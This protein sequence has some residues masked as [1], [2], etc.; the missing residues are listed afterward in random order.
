M[1]YPWIHKKKRQSFQYKHVIKGPSIKVIL[2]IFN[3][4]IMPLSLIYV[5]YTRMKDK[6]KQ[7]IIRR[8][9]KEAEPI[10]FSKINNSIAYA[11]KIGKHMYNSIDMHPLFIAQ[12]AKAL[13]ID[14]N[15]VNLLVIENMLNLYC[16]EVQQA[17]SG[18]MALQM[19]EEYKYDLIFMDHIMPDMDGIETTRLIRS[20]ENKNKNT[21]IIVLSANLWDN[22]CN[23]FLSV[24]ANEV[25]QKP[26]EINI[27][28]DVLKKWLP[29]HK[30]EPL[31]QVDKQEE[32]QIVMVDSK[33]QILEQ[34]IDDIADIDLNSGLK[35]SFGNLESFYTILNLA[36][37]EIVPIIQKIEIHHKNGEMIELQK[38]LHSLEN[39]LLNI[40][41]N[42]LTTWTRELEVAMR[43]ENYKIVDGELPGLMSCLIVLS[44]DLEIMLGT[45]QIV[46]EE[47]EQEQRAIQIE[48]S[49]FSKDD[50]IKDLIQL[51][52]CLSISDYSSVITLFKILQKNYFGMEQEIMEE[53]CLHIMNFEYNE[54]NKIVQ[55]FIKQYGLDEHMI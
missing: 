47:Y 34:L 33:Y 1:R 23:Q 27:L 53:L 48:N 11:D 50:F 51:S 41:A 52:S 37:K 30:I 25:L 40:G 3:L 24:K 55:E 14:D 38:S 21:P 45:Y 18:Y 13:V 7:R 19:A 2:F 44:K 49:T 42:E 26:M 16:I 15:E 6:Y 22:I 4:V 35:L 10:E 20:T 12:D 9:I 32:K 5:V 17:M 29:K 46:I 31:S 43:L 28:S 36:K 54:A 39:I 8:I